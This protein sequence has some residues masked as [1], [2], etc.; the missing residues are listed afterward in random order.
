M[1]KSILILFLLA[2]ISIHAQD[3]LKKIRFEVHGFVKADFWVDSR[4][5]VQALEGLFMLYPAKVSLD[6]DGKDINAHPSF[7]YSA[8]S[9][10]IN[11]KMHGPD[12]FGAKTTAFLESDYT[13]ISN[14]TLNT[15][16]LRHAW[17][18][19]QW[20]RWTVIMGQD[21]HPM[22]V[23]EVFPGVLALNTGTPFQPFIRNPQLRIEYKMGN[24][25]W[26]GAVL[27]Q[28]DN[29]NFG[30]MGKD[31]SYLTNS[32]VPNIHGQWKRHKGPH[33]MGLA[34]DWKS[35]MPRLATDS[36]TY[37]RE[38]LNS[39]A[40][41]AYYKLE[42]SQL[43]WKTKTIYGENLTEHLMLGG[44]AVAQIDSSNDAR[45]YTSSRHIF[46]WTQVLWKM[47]TKKTLWM[48]GIFVGYAKNL[49]SPID[50]LG[51]WYARGADI[52]QVMRGAL[53]LFIQQGP[54]MF[55]LEYELTRAYYGDIEKSGK[56][57]NA[58]PVDIHRFEV[59]AFYFF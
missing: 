29:S 45:S 40:F 7:N 48:P 46:A 47:N 32:M 36:G 14:Q 27:S 49:G 22:F 59:S 42:N 54:L 10:R 23:Q 37:T 34:A 20:P 19:M 51:I 11:V 38:T 15:L 4:Q 50:N 28:R 17:I 2:S 18:K 44:Y 16:R 21:W 13:G 30:P 3:S 33:T 39:K 9:S 8:M 43:T 52:D 58:K 24:S 41:M 6:Q 25:R 26:I 1:R 31:F 53:D 5:V 35:V 55:S 56:V 12:A 57:D